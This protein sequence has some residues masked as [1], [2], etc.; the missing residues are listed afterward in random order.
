LLV[1][2]YG[3]ASGIV[4]AVFETFE[5]I[6]DDGDGALGTYIA[7]NST[8]GF[9]VRNASSSGFPHTDRNKE[10]GDGQACEGDYNRRQTLHKNGT[11]DMDAGQVESA[12]CA[13]GGE[14]IGDCKDKVAERRKNRAQCQ[15]PHYGQQALARPE[16][17]PR[18]RYRGNDTDKHS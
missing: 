1:A 11:H 16:G 8:H 15:G 9:I 18:S 7:D 6:H 4:S 17:K 12:H 13:Y 2:V 14:A 10:P 3:N 5:A